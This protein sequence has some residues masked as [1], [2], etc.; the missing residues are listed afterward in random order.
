MAAAVTV[1]VTVTVTITVTVTVTYI[2]RKVY[3][4]TFYICYHFLQKLKITYV[5][6]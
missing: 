5:I 4:Y 1:T 6:N 3:I 2:D